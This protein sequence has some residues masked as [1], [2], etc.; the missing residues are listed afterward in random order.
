MTN[1]PIRDFELYDA[2]Q[3]EKAEKLPRCSCCGE[4]IFDDYFY[5]IDDEIYC[6]DCLNNEFREWNN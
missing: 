3:E 1:D 2:E 4:P 5:R 6:E